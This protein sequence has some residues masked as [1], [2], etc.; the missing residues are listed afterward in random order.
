MKNLKEVL[1]VC[2]LLGRNLIIE[3]PTGVGKTTGGI[4]VCRELVGEENL[5]TH[6]GHKRTESID[7]LGMYVR[8]KEGMVF[9]DG[10]LTKAFINALVNKTILFIDEIG[11]I[12]DSEKDLL[13]GCLTADDQGYYILDTGKGI[14]NLSGSRHET[15][16]VRVPSANLIVVGTTNL[17]E[18]FATSTGDRAFKER[19]L[20]MHISGNVN[21]QIL[22]KASLSTVDKDELELL[23]HGFSNAKDKGLL[24]DHMNFRFADMLL[25][26]ADSSISA[27]VKTELIANEFNDKYLTKKCADTDS[28]L[29]I[30]VSFVN[31]EAVELEEGP[32]TIP[33]E[34]LEDIRTVAER[35][36]E[37]M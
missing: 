13:I 5:F 12:P 4:A 28:L 6:R 36:A 19:F 34:E 27:N 3:G 25:V 30:L 23:L 32:S 31:Q 2:G 14:E 22:E 20:N 15:E 8:D 24:S 21:E 17:G 26:L 9:N 33:S 29:Q 1:E 37:R 11:R 7:L 18:G 16:V 35:M 10:V